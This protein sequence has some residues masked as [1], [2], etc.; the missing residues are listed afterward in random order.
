M[1]IRVAI[2]DDDKSVCRSLGRLLCA[3]GMEA[4]SYPSAEAFLANRK[5][6]SFDCLILDIHLGGMSGLDLQAMLV[7]EGETVPIIFITAHDSVASRREALAHGCAGFFRKADP[8]ADI[9]AAI[10]A[11]I[12][13]P[14]DATQTTAQVIK[15]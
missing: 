15:E 5:T 10:H 9:I 7:A 12:W 3:A 14:E 11:A 6:Q 2:V 4:T 13:H 1:N 8:G